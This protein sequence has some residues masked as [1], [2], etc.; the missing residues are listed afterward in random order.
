MG[1]LDFF[2]ATENNKLKD[3]IIS[4]KSKISEYENILTPEVKD[5]LNIT[6]E[7]STL[8][9]TKNNIIDEISL[10]KK[11]K[12]NLEIEIKRKTTELNLLNEDLDLAEQGLYKPSFDFD[13][14]KEYKAALDDIKL[15]QKAM[16]KAK[17]AIVVNTTWTVGGS[18]SK[19]NSLTNNGIRQMLLTFN[20]EC[21]LLISKAKYNNI[22]TLRNKMETLYS[23]INNL[24]KHLG[25]SINYDYLHCRLQELTLTYEYQVKLQNE[26]EEQKRIKELMREEALLKQELE[27]FRKNTTKDLKHYSTELSRIEEKLSSNILDSEKISLL[28]KQTEIQEKV[29]D[30]N[31]KLQDADYRQQNQKAGY[32][33]VISNIGSFGENVYKIGMTRRLEPM[34]RINELGSASVPFNFDVHAMIFSEDAPKLEASL[35]RAFELKKVNMVNTRREFFN[36]TLDEIEAVVKNNFD[37]TVEFIKAAEAAQY[38]ETLKIKETLNADLNIA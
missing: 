4:L 14:S 35:H 6:T 23:K 8:I 12:E 19:G 38:R 10:L 32:V 20:S 33:Y 30:L 29:E 22:V 2:K 17:T 16:M 7:I 18:K 31:E 24:N 26:K 37:S 11:E 25:L 3:E 1:L 27:N 21:D 9:K 5:C 28:S 15:K 36:V 34:D 13:T